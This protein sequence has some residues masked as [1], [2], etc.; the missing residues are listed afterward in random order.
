MMNYLS[1]H[2]L[3]W[4]NTTVTGNTVPY[5]YE[6]LEEAMAAQYSYGRSTDTLAQAANL[7]ATFLAK[8]PFAY[9]NRRTAFIAVATFLSANGYTLQV[10][11]AR[12]AEIVQAVAEGSMKAQEAVAA[13]SAPTD[14]RLAPGMAIRKLVTHLCNEHAEALKRLTEGDG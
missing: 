10:D 8:Q 2:D 11:D 5:H 13:L 1:V 12:A 6:R 9:G 7:L 14:A 3:V 4:I